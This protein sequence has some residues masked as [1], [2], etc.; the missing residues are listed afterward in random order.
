MQRLQNKKPNNSDPCWT[1]KKYNIFHEF[2]EFMRFFIFHEFHECIVV[3]Y[4]RGIIIRISDF[5][6]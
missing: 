2:H 6:F 4:L 5:L 1:M 3:I